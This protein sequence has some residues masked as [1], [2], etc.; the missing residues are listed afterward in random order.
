MERERLAKQWLSRLF[1][2]D[3]YTINRLSGDASFRRYYRLQHR[4]ETFL[5]MDAPPGK[6][7]CHRFVDVG[8]R[9]S[10]CGIKTPIVHRADME[11]GFLLLE[12]LGKQRYYDVMPSNHFDRMYRVAL[13]MLDNIS[14]AE[15]NGLPAYD[16][17]IILEE[18]RLFSDWYCTRH[19]RLDLSA[20][21]QGLLSEL[22]DLLADTMLEQP[23]VFVHMDYHSKNLMCC[24]QQFG[25]LDY[26]DASCG[27]LLYDVASLCKDCYLRWPVP[28]VD[29][30]LEFWWRRVGSLH[31]PGAD[32]Q[33]CR[34]WFDLTAV[35]R[36]LK[37]TGIFARLNYRD[38]K[39]GYLQDIPR[40]LSYVVETA[41]RYPE[42]HAFR[43]FLVHRVG[44][45]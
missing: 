8:A 44:I 30:W 26:Q 40:T 17:A 24:G 14:H 4:R 3:H 36:H 1:N 43:D 29:E 2:G 20:A 35:Q 38:G 11:L 12:D 5:L 41:E 32:L 34:R 28:Q 7:D 27:A 10:L 23:Q 9:L 13:S 16:R 6:E 42:L 33:L 39:P 37:A 15:L 45:V 22:F 25:V 19:L 31:A 21:D 18:M